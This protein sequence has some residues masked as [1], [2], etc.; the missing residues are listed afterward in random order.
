MWR[1]RFLN[2]TF[3]LLLMILTMR[4]LAFVTQQSEQVQ[5]PS[6]RPN[7]GYSQLS[8]SLAPVV[9]DLGQLW[10]RTQ[11]LAEWPIENNTTQWEKFYASTIVEK[12]L[13]DARFHV[14]NAEVYEW[15]IENP[16]KTIAELNRA[17]RVLSDARPSIQKPLLATIE[18]V[19]KELETMEADT[20]GE[21]ASQPANYEAVKTDL[22]HV[23][24][25][26][27]TVGAKKVLPASANRSS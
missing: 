20:S 12:E 5:A 10:R 21:G 24:D 19:T 11:I 17:E 16:K 14:E 25:R 26:I 1:Q 8:A 13:I 15:S 7:G 27:R 3:V 18:R 4:N 6:A 9:R 2:L 22:D 23:I